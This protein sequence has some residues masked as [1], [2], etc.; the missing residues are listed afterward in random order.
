[1]SKI[2]T[3]SFAANAGASNR[4]RRGFTLMELLVYVGVFSVASV[5]LTNILLTVTNISSRES[6][7]RE[8]SSQ[9]DTTL[10][11]IQQLIQ[12][13]ST[14]ESAT[15]STLKLRMSDPAKDPTCITLESGVIKI[16]Q[17]P[18]TPADECST[19]KTDLTTSK[20]VADSLAFTKIDNIQYSETE[21][22]DLVGHSV[23][24]IDMAMTYNTSN[25]K[26]E[27]SRTLSSAIGRV[28]AATFD[29]DLLPDTANTRS[30]G[31]SALK[32]QNL[33]VNGTA[34]FAGSVGINVSTPAQKLDVNGSIKQGKIVLWA[35][36]IG[37][38]DRV[39][40]QVAYINF[41]DI[42]W[43]GSVEI[44]ITG[45]WN[46]SPAFGA[47]TK[48]FSFYHAAAGT[49]YSNYI[50][51]VTAASGPVATNY[52]IG[53]LE[54]YETSKLRIPIY[55]VNDAASNTL[56]TTIKIFSTNAD[57]MANA[58]TITAPATVTN[59][60]TRNNVSF[61]DTSVGIGTNSPAYKL[62]VYSAAG[63]TGS[64][65]LVGAG[66]SGNAQLVLDSA[67]GDG[68]GAD[69][70]LLAHNRADNN[71]NIG[72][73]GASNLVITSDGKVGVGAAP[74]Y[75]LD[76]VSGGA[77]TARFG[78][79]AG[80]TVVVGGGSGKLT[81][82]TVDPL[83]NIDGRQ[84]AT[85]TPG[86]TGVKE[87]TAGVLALD[88]MG[89]GRLSA[90]IDFGAA[91]NGS[92]LWIFRNVTDFGDDWEN[93]GV[94]LTPGFI[95]R[96]SY[97]KDIRNNRI[98]ITGDANETVSDFEVSYRLTAPRFDHLDWPNIPLNTEPGIGLKVR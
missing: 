57:T 87:E 15:G 3:G 78:S 60:Y 88:N 52:A 85:Y 29:S 18:G 38:F 82:G 40:D 68:A 71:L 36:A 90:E 91:E 66:T 4:G 96:V 97:K 94:L 32:W 59:T 1:M 10:E 89:N 84:Y 54:I 2:K 53:E 44:N 17:G 5:F 92:D 77:T 47:L 41:G 39:A 95:G 81:V 31:T 43:L 49:S 98:I 83:F 26:Y 21:G 34:Y 56:Y 50:S 9:L 63:G 13:S 65:I 30:I 42:G 16:A 24:N 93:L 86:M 19:T 46:Y 69:Y 80:D 48:R 70:Y 58:I 12:Q 64:T 8:V 27:I 28:S 14:I 62:H 72:Y 45:G 67:N 51:E 79:A 20:V 61:M 22:K 55:Q 23:V 76:V 25:P 7:S 73:G 11:T 35:G 74:G 6:A 37:T 33:N 75:K